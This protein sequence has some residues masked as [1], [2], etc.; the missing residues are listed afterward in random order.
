[1]C[2]ATKFKVDQPAKQ[3]KKLCP[4]IILQADNQYS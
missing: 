1:M 3:A 4:S 2:L